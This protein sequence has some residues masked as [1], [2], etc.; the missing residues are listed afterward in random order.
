MKE[1]SEWLQGI[2]MIALGEWMVYCIM[3]MYHRF[4]MVPKIRSQEAWG[5]N[6]SLKLSLVTIKPQTSSEYD[7]VKGVL[8]A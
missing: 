7:W 1:T 8:F 5:L 6:I 2:A 4:V 3:Y